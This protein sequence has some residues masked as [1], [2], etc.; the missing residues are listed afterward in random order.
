V[1]WEIK[2]TTDHSHFS[3]LA[4]PKYLYDSAIYSPWQDLSIEFQK[5]DKGRNTERDGTELSREIK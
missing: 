4:K 3:H 2:V 1:H 5:K